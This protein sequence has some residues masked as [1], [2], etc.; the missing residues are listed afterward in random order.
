MSVPANLQIARSEASTATRMQALVIQN[1][2]PR[3]ISGFKK[4]RVFLL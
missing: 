1:E 3:T 2:I 4:P